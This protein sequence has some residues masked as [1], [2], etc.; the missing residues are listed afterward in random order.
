MRIAKLK[1]KQVKKLEEN[2]ELEAPH[3][4]IREG[5]L[6]TYDVEYKD[7]SE[8][9]IDTATETEKRIIEEAN[10]K[11]EED[12]IDFVRKNQIRAGSHK[13]DSSEGMVKIPESK[14]VFFDTSASLYLKKLFV[15]FFDKAGLLQNKFKRNKRA[16]LLHSAPGMGKSA[17][18][19][20]FCRHALRK[21]G[22]AVIVVDGEVN[23]AV[24]SNIFLKPYAED[25]NRII[26]II[27]DFGRKDS[28]A[29]GTIYNPAC[30]NFLDGTSGLFRVPT[31][32]LCTTNYAKELGP[33]LTNR[34][35]RF[36]KIIEVL[37]P[38]D[39]E[40]F[41]LV[42]GIGEIKLS[43]SEKQVF[44]GKN[45]SPDHV[46]EAIIRHEMEE[47]TLEHSVAQIIREREGLIRP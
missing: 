47:V 26:L 22:T 39:D 37:P 40:I 14:E 41:Q 33:Q 20:E 2:L 12:W 36:N 28:S 4:T 17:L 13:F 34:P 35:G 16:Y 46:I 5:K 7:I 21:D 44:R 8:Q 45:L 30:L 25:V 15:N 6:I 32:I 18:I 43:E 9:E 1:I 31:M 23:F 11:K 29:A 42:E 10:K 19:R 38:S 27:E 3:W 24:L